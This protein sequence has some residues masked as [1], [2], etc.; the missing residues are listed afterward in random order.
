MDIIKKMKGIFKTKDKAKD[1]ASEYTEKDPKRKALIE[2]KAKATKQGK[3]WVAVL[4]AWFKD[5][6]RNI[7][8]EQGQNPD[9]GMGYININRMDDDKS[10]VS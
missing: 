7:L 8:K 5:I 4:D 9:T 10:E 3:P 2:E 6:A 1:V